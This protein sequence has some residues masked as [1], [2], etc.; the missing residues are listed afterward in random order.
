MDCFKLIIIINI[1]IINNINVLYY[2]KNMNNFYKIIEIFGDWRLGP[3]PIKMN[4]KLLF[5]SFYLIFIL[6]FDLFIHIIK[7]IKKI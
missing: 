7:L 2:F 3:I 1:I 5:I 6:L 4:Y